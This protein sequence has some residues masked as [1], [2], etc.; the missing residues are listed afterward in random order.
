MRD[1]RRMSYAR[2]AE[3]VGERQGVSAAAMQA[4]KADSDRGGS[5]FPEA[6]IKV[7]A[8]TE[9][10]LM[11]IVALE[12]GLPIVSVASHDLDRE[13]VRSFPPELVA[14]SLVV[15]LDRFQKLMTVAMPILAPADVLEQFA[16]RSRCEICPVVSGL[17]ENRHLVETTLKIRREEGADA[18]WE[19][20]FDEA[21]AAVMRESK[22]RR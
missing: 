15:P 12:F 1:L 17:E 11:R 20:L 4:A 16:G 8:L 22:R 9:W 3:I 6:L 13:L 10:E 5:L 18:G 7:G 14:Q 19:K 21:N 2:L